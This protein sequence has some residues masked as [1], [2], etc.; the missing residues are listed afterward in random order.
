MPAEWSAKDARK[1]QI[2]IDHLLTMAS[3]LTPDDK[4]KQPNYLKL[5][6]AQPVRAAPEREWSYQ[7]M[8]VD[9]LGVAMQRLAGKPVRE[10]FN[11]HIASPIGV[12][13]VAW[14]GFDGYTRARA[15][16]RCRRAIS[17]ASAT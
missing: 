12:P 16:P 11:Q 13:N 3:G 1:K 8:S 4:P 10:L 6:M 5:I 14:D 7:S 17:P 2:R 9:L 15:A